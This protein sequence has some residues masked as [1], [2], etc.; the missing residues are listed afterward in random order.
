MIENKIC[1]NG[2]AFASE[3]HDKILGTKAQDAL[4]E[5][6][7][8]SQASVR[9]ERIEISVSTVS[10]KHEPEMITYAYKGS[11]NALRRSTKS[12]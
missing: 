12:D 4:N 8:Q 9:D 6:K 7:S 10:G 2:Y 5:G 1:K 3:P 11:Y